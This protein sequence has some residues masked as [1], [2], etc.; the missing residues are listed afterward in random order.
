MKHS[1]VW[2]TLEG[3]SGQWPRGPSWREMQGDSDWRARLA[4]PQV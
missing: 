4:G 2:D 3:E 1:I